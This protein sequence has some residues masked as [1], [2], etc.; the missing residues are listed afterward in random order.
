MNGLVKSLHSDVN[1]MQQGQFETV[2]SLYLL[3]FILF[4]YFLNFL[5]VLI[6]MQIR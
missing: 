6:N 2:F 1:N 5:S 4:L 3:F